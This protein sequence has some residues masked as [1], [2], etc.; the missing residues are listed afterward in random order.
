MQSDH[1]LRTKALIGAVVAVT[2]A[3]A[4]WIGLSSATDRGI[5]RLSAI[6]R[7]RAQCAISWNAARTHPETLLVDRIALTD[8]IDPM[9][10][11]ALTACGDLRDKS[12][13]TTLPNTRE[14]NG[15]PMPQGLR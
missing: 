12:A 5:A 1:A 10:S 7:G 6:D 4:G 13:R 3:I 14:M 2:V 11:T 9:S 15:E 8:T